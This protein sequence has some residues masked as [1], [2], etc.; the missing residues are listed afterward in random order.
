MHRGLWGIQVATENYQN[1]LSHMR[2]DSIQLKSVMCQDAIQ[3]V[4][5]FVVCRDSKT[6]LVE[7]GKVS[8]VPQG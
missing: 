8:P 6:H 4:D 5:S 3:L 2:N 7:V 1:I